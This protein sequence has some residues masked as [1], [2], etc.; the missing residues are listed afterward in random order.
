MEDV[1]EWSRVHES[2][3]RQFM[4]HKNG[5]PSEDT[6]LRLF[7]LL[8]PKC[9]EACFRRWVSQVVTQLSGMIAIDGKTV[10]GSGSGG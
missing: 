10:R 8:D 3:L 9:F 2:W 6:F 1:V 7:R 5:I 4:A